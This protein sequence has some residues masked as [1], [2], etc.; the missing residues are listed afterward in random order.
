MKPDRRTFLAAAAGAA[1][2]TAANGSVDWRAIRAEFPWVEKQLFL[3]PA[4]WH[5]MRKKAVEAMQRYLDFKLLGPTEGRGAHASGH[6]EDARRLFAK[7]INARPAEIAFV[8]STL[9]GENVVVSALGIPGGK[10]NVV[11]DELH[12]EG[13]L[14]M[15][16]SLQKQ[17]LDLRIVKLKDQRIDPNDVD[18]AVDKNT[19][20]VATSLVSCAN[21]CRA[22]AKALSEIAHAKGAYLYTDVIQAAG[23]VPIDVRALGIDFCACSGYKF[24]M[25]DRGL[26]FLYAREDLIGKVAKRFQFGD[27]QFNDFQYH[28]F[29]N[30][31]AGPRPATW[32]TRSGAGGHFEVG[33]IA[34]VVAA[35]HAENLR[36]ILDLGVD[37]IQAHAKPMVE[38]LRKELPKLGYPLMTPADTPT[39]TTSFV[40]AD[41]AKL[42][43]KMKRANI[44]VKQQWSQMRVSVSVYHE[45]S[46]IDRFLNAFG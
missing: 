2:A 21:G 32:E 20:L 39:P 28:I 24:L 29:P 41:Q 9:M 8:Q 44:D 45:M 18:K 12:Y 33:N 35:G 7:L 16:S 34:T 22:N 3:N 40:V 37:R 14:Y 25:G 27:R 43:A 15:Y 31:P 10:W 6:Q 30:D 38:R 19:R 46:D 23:A 4:G 36:F 1:T 17:G 13:S 42:T 11:T 5:P 26:G